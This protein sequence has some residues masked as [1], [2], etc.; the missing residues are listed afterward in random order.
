MI[1]IIQVGMGGWGQNWARTVV[2]R[3]AGVEPVAFVDMSAQMLEKAQ[4]SLGIAPEQCFPTL[5][6]ALQGVEADAVL[7]TANLPA[8]VPVALA[9]LA[10]GKHVLLEK[11]FAPSL[12]E[13][14]R[15]VEAAAARNRILMISQNYRFFPAARTA[16][17]LVQS[18]ELGPVGAVAID[19]RRYA[20]TAPREGHK[21]YT[22]YQPLLADM[23]IHHF[24]LMRMILGQEAQT[25]ACHAWNPPWSNFEQPSTAAA[26]ITFDGGAVVSYRGSWASP[27]AQTTWSGEWRIECA[28][29]EIAWTG[30]GDGQKLSD[31]RVMVRKIGAKRAKP[32]ELVSLPDVDRGGTLQAFV[33]AIKNDQ[34]PETSGRDNLHTLALMNAAIEASQTGAPVI[35]EQPGK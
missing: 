8:H 9:A 1:R 10:A 35:V 17:A 27:G 14:L 32:V 30:R 34:E 7:I 23:S 15:V 16:A 26:T 33:D 22:I 21:H 28:E 11:P 29:G 25:V 13:G 3:V 2:P 6:A 24:D 5:D 31:E 12:V 4:E 19:F 20:N 18:G